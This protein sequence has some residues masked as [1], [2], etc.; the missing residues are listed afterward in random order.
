MNKSE[1]IHF[2]VNIKN[3]DEI[4]QGEEEANDEVK[5]SIHRLHTFFAGISSA[6]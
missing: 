3:L 1:G 4:I 5:R 2:Y 6:T